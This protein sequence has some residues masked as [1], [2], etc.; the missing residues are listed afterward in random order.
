MTVYFVRMLER[1]VQEEEEKERKKI[2]TQAPTRR[3]TPHWTDDDK[4]GAKQFGAR[5]STPTNIKFGLVQSMTFIWT[6]HIIFYESN[7]KS[8]MCS[9]LHWPI[10]I[11][12]V[13]VVYLLFELKSQSIYFSLKPFWE[14]IKTRTVEKK[15]PSKCQ[16]LRSF[17]SSMGRVAVSFY[18]SRWICAC[19]KSHFDNNLKL[20][21]IKLDKNIQR[22]NENV[23]MPLTVWMHEHKLSKIA[24]INYV[25]LDW[26]TFFNKYSIYLVFGQFSGLFKW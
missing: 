18:L 20:S 14:A 11:R 26:V 8:L 9:L 5:K 15:F 23:L 17:F 22:T 7:F 1:S 4:V 13:L 2:S 10:T 16:F 25:W 6:A 12:K 24:Q 19:A 3:T 21:L